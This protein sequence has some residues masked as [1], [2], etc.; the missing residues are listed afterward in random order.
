VPVKPD[1]EYTDGDRQSGI[2]PEHLLPDEPMILGD[3][4][5][6]LPEKWPCPSLL[7]VCGLCNDESKSLSDALRH[8]GTEHPDSPAEPMCHV[9]AVPADE[10]YRPLWASPNQ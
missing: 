7:H 1:M 8:I 10:D 3:W 9:Y 6:V 4:G 2:V 5:T